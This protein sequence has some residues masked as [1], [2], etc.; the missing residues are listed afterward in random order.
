MSE[1]QPLLCTVYRCSREPEMYVYV[2]RKE[3]LSRV[4]EELQRR[5]G[6]L[7]EVMTI[8]LTPERKLARAKAPEVL[9]AIARQGFYLQLPPSLQPLQFTLGE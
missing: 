3:G 1:S 4:P 9:E 7:S 6:T 8:K 5:A 2:D